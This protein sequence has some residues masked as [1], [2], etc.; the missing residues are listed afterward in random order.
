MT[1]HVNACNEA[2]TILLAAETPTLQHGMRHLLKK[3]GFE[4]LVAADGREVLTTL[5]KASRPPI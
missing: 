3:E 4:V 2:T 5:R 1:D